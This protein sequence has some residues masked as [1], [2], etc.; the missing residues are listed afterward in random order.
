MGGAL[1]LG[2]V[3]G[4]ASGDI[5]ASRVVRALR[6]HYD[7]VTLQGMGGPL[8]EA[9][10][11]NSL[12]P[13]ERLAVMGFVEPVKRL[14][15]LLSMR[16]ELYRHFSEQP[17]D[18]FLGVDSPDF[19]L[20]L[21]LKLRAQ[22]IRTAHL[23]SPSVWAWR[24]GRLKKISRAVDLM[25]CLFPFETAIYEEHGVRAAFVGHPL[26]DELRDLP[27]AGAVRERLG[28]PGER[29]ILAILPGSRGGEVRMLAPLFLE[30]ATRLASADNNLHFVLPAANA[31]RRAELQSMLSAYPGL[32]L[33]LIDGQSR[34]AMLAADAVLLASGT[35]TLEAMLLR[36]PMVVAYRMA[37]LSWALVSRMVTTEFAGLP[38]ILA[39]RA[40]VPEL[41]QDDATVS[42]LV[43]AINPLLQDPRAREA[44]LAVFDD[45]HESLALGYAERCA[46]AIAGATSGTGGPGAAV[47]PD[48]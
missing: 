23:V 41:I 27:A 31:E 12:F 3:V 6:Q 17:P 10:G 14:P 5:L 20:R 8:L 26:A 13:M 21:E 7:E 45:L 28:L 22:G 38:N 30:T 32:P 33:T 18:L 2:L 48:G 29:R 37:S 46:R 24:R 25:L 47:A 19:N 43:D 42:G 36:R 9:E 34:E 39:G 35:A 40:V 11:L 1:R 44:Q 15:E 4:E 16:A